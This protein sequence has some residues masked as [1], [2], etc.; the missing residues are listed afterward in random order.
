[1]KRIRRFNS[2]N[3]VNE[4]FGG[5]GILA[6]IGLVFLAPAIY[7]QARKFWSKHIIGDKYTE[8][9]KKEIVETKLPQNISYTARLTEEERQSGIVK[10]ELKQYKDSIGNL[11]WGYDHLYTPDEY[12]DYEESVANLDMY[13]AMFLEEDYQELK[14]FLQNSERYTGKGVKFDTKPIDMIFREDWNENEY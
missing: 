10:T 8:T 14:S 4:E 3:S 13:T 2:Y 12:A 6:G 7:D 1:M 11:Y 5:L 9:G